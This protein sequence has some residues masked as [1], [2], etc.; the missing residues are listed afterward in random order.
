MKVLRGSSK[1][2]LLFMIANCGT[3]TVAYAPAD[4]AE[5]NQEMS[6][7]YEE[8][9]GDAEAI[10]TTVDKPFRFL[11]QEDDGDSYLYYDDNT[12]DDIAD[13]HDV[14]LIRSRQAKAKSP[15]APKVGKA[16]K[17]AC[18]LAEDCND[19]GYC[20]KGYCKKCK[21]DEECQA[22]IDLNDVAV[23]D[24]EGDEC[25]VEGEC[26]EEV[27]RIRGAVLLKDLMP[28][29]SIKESRLQII[30][31]VG[32]DPYATFSY[33]DRVLTEKQSLAVKNYILTSAVK[34]T[35]PEVGA[36][37]VPITVETLVEL[38]GIDSLHN[39]LDYYSES[40]NSK[41]NNCD[42]VN[43][44]RIHGRY[45]PASEYHHHFHRDEDGSTLLIE[46]NAD[47]YDGGEV[48]YLA[49]DGPFVPERQV[50]SAI[51][52]GSDIAHAVT[53][54][55]SKT[56]KNDSDATAESDSD[57]DDEGGRYSLF[58]LSSNNPQKEIILNAG[59]L[60]GSMK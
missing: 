58:F 57:G 39:I 15:K 37:N 18:T 53:T 50:G 24:V 51:V 60:L 7:Y 5:S 9:Y 22:C 38:I 33:K 48:V 6:D 46:L 12:N 34:E 56:T 35:R 20:Y 59:M 29:I 4:D 54:H 45:M 30:E 23:C 11:D 40:L 13:H 43:V 17:V 1:M 31:D 25:E 36:Y 14:P 42:D 44:T 41:G 3:F 21:S 27:K 8:F 49:H 52:H 10:K 16:S 32:A 26:D 28:T 55:T 2:V 47:D 19:Q